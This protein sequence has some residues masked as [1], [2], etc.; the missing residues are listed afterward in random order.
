MLLAVFSAWT[1]STG[2]S[3]L[4][5]DHAVVPWLSWG[6]AAGMFVAVSN[7]GLPVPPVT[8]SPLG[9]SLVR[10]T[11][12]GLFAFFVVAPAVVGPQ[13]QGVVRRVL[14]TRPL[15]FLGTVS[16]GIYLWHESWINMFLRWTGERVFT[17]SFLELFFFVTLAATAAASVSY[18]LVERPIIGARLRA[19]KPSVAEVHSGQHSI[20]A[21]GARS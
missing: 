4:A 8:P 21:A 12:Y 1:A 2:V 20:A 3:V 15:V 11:L 9:L 14:Q 17:I 6:V 7:L 18:F 16:Y 10:Q 5:L 13:S 19:P